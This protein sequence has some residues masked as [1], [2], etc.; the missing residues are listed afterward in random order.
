MKSTRLLPYAAVLTAFTTLALADAAKPLA[1]SPAP[2]PGKEALHASF[3]EISKQGEAPLVFLGDSITQGWSGKGKTAW[4]RYWAP[5]GAANF[6]IGGDRTEH[7]LWR[8][9]NGNYDGLKPKLTVLMIGTNNTGHQGRPM[10]EHGGA[11]YSSTAE[12]TAAG[13]AEIVKVLK[14]KQPQMKILLLAIFPRGATPEDAMRRQ[15]EKTNRLIAKLD[16]G[17]TVFF[18]DINKDFLESDGTLSNEIMPDLLHPNEKGY[19]IWSK[20]IGARV[21]ALMAE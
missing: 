3:N 18:L 7:I 4:E 11:V 1:L 20:A 9:A 17:K 15:N 5:M 6:G 8:L 16:D 19:E 10:A 13:V 2:H 12:E 21:K 14:E